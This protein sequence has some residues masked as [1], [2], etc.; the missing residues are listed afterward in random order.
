MGL[1]IYISVADTTMGT[2]FPPGMEEV[3]E[4]IAS[5]DINDADDILDALSYITS[6]TSAM[7]KGPY[8]RSP[9][10]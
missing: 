10:A 4:D 7:D 3:I 2:A 9:T 8:K 6:A 5:F 1:G